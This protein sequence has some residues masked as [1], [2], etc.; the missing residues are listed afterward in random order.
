MNS[1]VRILVFVCCL[2]TVACLSAGHKRS[3]EWKRDFKYLDII[4][5]EHSKSA[6][7][8]LVCDGYKT[9]KRIESKETTTS[10]GNQASGSFDRKNSKSSRSDFNW[11]EQVQCFMKD[12]DNSDQQ[13]AEL[14]NTLV[15]TFVTLANHAYGDFEHDST[16]LR[17]LNNTGFE[18]INLGLTA[19]TTVFGLATQLGAA[20]TAMQGAQHSADK[21]FYSSETAYVINSKMESLRLEQ[22]AKIRKLESLKVNCDPPAAKPAEESGKGSQPPC[23]TFEQAM[24]DVQELYYAGS[25]HRALQDI[26]N[27]TAAKTGQAKAELKTM[28]DKTVPA[29]PAD[30]P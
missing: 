9:G 26:N 15:E 5:E 13:K 29:A 4:R 27:Q 28:R 20:A 22:L 6:K 2:P 18:F 21:N 8:N 1:T 16:F 7:L 3:K 30:Q 10:I 11:V 12:K 19:G 23:Y 24:G 25:V 17:E 14:R